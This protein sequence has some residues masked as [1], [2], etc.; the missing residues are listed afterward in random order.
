M[1]DVVTPIMVCCFAFS[2]MLGFMETTLTSH[3]NE[4][5]KSIDDR[6]DHRFGG[7]P[8]CSPVHVPPECARNTICG[9]LI[10]RNQTDEAGFWHL[11]LN[12][13]LNIALTN[14]SM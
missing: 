13:A 12:M 10:H 11:Q 8:N 5:D 4:K 9:M 7:R 6:Q 3:S 14:P 1:I 2:R